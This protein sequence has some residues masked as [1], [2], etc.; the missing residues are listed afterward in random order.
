M[1]NVA[2]LILAIA[3]EHDASSQ[4]QRLSAPKATSDP[5]R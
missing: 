3:A 1:A 4:R 5:L 2:A